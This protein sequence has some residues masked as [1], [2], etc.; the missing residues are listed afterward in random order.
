MAS[1]NETLREE[2]ARC[3]EAAKQSKESNSRAEL[4]RLAANF[5][6]LAGQPRIDFDALL[7]D[8]NA[9]QMMPRP[10][11][12]SVVQQQQQQQQVQPKDDHKNE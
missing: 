12:E 7:A 1:R 3:L 6:E 4:V 11:A 9:Q 2:A 5:L 8:Y 10:P